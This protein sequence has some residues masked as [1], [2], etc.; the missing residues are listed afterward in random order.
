[1]I[2]HLKFVGLPVKDQD[3]ALK[4]WTELMGFKVMTDQPM[5]PGQRWIE[6]GIG[7]SQTLLVLFSPEGSRSRR[8]LLQRLL[9]LRRRRSD[10]PSAF[11][12]RREIRPAAEEGRL[13]HVGAVRRL[14]RQPVRAE[15]SVTRFRWDRGRLVR[16]SQ[17]QT[18]LRT[19]RPR[20][21]EVTA[22]AQTPGYRRPDRPAVRAPRNG[23]L[24][25]I[26]SSARRS[27]CAR[28]GS[29]AGTG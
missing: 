14:G 12:Q 24:P 6:L 18:M 19:G 20:P 21:S 2:T 17:T 28:P 29:S 16:I 15:F 11:R 3:K 23:R 8:Q 27:L 7:N 26:P 5:G 13:G 22:L 9:R 1:M 4:F 25:R 10:V